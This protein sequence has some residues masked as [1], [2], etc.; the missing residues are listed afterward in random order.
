MAVLPNQIRIAELDFDQILANFIAFMK[1]DP[2]FSDY[3]FSGS[4]LRMLARFHAY[5]TFYNNYYLTQ[6]V[7]ESFLD[8]AQLRS[9]VAAHARML[10]YNIKGTQSARIRANVAVQ[11]S[12]T[13]AT[14]VT[15]PKNTQFSLVA[16]TQFSFYNTDD[17]PLTKNT[18]TLLYEAANADLVEGAPLTYRFT[19]DTTDPS[20][21]FIIPN[22]NVD[23]RTVT[24]SV[25]ASVSSNVQTSFSRETNYIAITPTDPVFFVTEAYNGFPELTFGNGVVGKALDNGNIII[26]NYY[27]SKGEIGNSI[28]GP[29][30]IGTANIAGFVRGVTVTD[31]NTVPSSGGTDQED[32]DNARFLAPLVY[33]SQNRCVTADDYKAV[34]MAFYG[35]NIAAINVFGG[36]QGDPN[37]PLERPTFGRVFIALKPKIGLR[38]TD[39][40]RLNI[41]QNI[42]QPRSIVGVIP[43]VIDPDYIWINVATSVKYDAKSTSQTKLQLADAIRA[44]VLTFALQ[45]V[46]KFDKVFRFSKFVRVIDDTDDAILSSV[47]RIDLEKRIYPAVNASNQFILKFG[48]PIRKSGNASAVLEATAHRFNYTND[49]GVT[50]NNC[51]FYESAGTLQIAYRNDMNQIAVFKSNIGSVDVV[52]GLITIV[53]FMPTAI[54]GDVSDVRLSIIPAVTDLAPRLNQLFT[55]D[56]A[57]VQVQLLND[58]SASLNDQTSFFSGGIL[59]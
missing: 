36:E 14:V 47:T 19:V 40:T 41:A 34:V 45:N 5:V 31:A 55:I 7:N 27:V 52:N 42:V 44:N 3:D 28:R 18:S 30:Q 25:Q 23:Y 12:N 58:T 26:A 21:R 4:A 48:V 37:D 15:L 20:Q 46:E 38:F 33:Q 11:L 39:I 49:R 51:F 43:E 53:N 24:V 6:A 16:N 9:S 32:L 57:A 59:P 13:S 29:F 17:V 10:G 8:T 50:Q 54:E 1:E 22:S 2:T 56:P 35:E